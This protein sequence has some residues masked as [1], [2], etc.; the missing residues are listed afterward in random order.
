MAKRIGKYK[1]TERES[2]LN[3]SDGGTVQGNLSV[4]GTTNV[5]G[6]LTRLTA[7]NIID[8]LME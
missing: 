3:L 6:V 7:E 5:T 1:I 2:A 8:W 4:S